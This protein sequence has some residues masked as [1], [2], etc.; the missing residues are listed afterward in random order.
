MTWLSA[1]VAIN[2]FH[3]E[4]PVFHL[5]KFACLCHSPT[6]LVYQVYGIGRGSSL[7]AC[8][9]DSVWFVAEPN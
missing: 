8:E 1:A 3:K 4:V 2:G 6:V 5:Y 9:I 7:A